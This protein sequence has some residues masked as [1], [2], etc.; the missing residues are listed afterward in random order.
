MEREVKQQLQIAADAAVE[1]KV[2]V[3][4][5]ADINSSQLVLVHVGK[6]KPQINEYELVSRM[7]QKAVFI[8]ESGQ[9]IEK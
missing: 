9:P 6:S 4:V 1:V 7:C 8:H 3:E 2:E 5:E